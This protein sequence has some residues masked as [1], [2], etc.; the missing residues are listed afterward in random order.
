MQEKYT[1]TREKINVFCMLKLWKGL[2]LKAVI[3]QFSGRNRRGE[4]GHTG[5]L[6]QDQLGASRINPCSRLYKKCTF[7][8]TG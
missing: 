4:G 2:N 3:I 8:K 1:L 7:D 6:L 5:L